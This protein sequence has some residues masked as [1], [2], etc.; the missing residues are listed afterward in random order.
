MSASLAVT[1]VAEHVWAQAGFDNR[2]IKRSGRKLPPCRK[3]SLAAPW[4]PAEIRHPNR[5]LIGMPK[6]LVFC[7]GGKRQIQSVSLRQSGRQM[8]SQW[9]PAHS[10]RTWTNDYLT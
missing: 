3:P 10:S 7:I 8:P 1:E 5:Q 9:Y 6:P 2:F 4:K